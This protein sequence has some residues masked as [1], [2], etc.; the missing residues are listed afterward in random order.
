VAVFIN[1]ERELDFFNQI[2]NRRRPGPAQLVLLYG[3]RRIGKTALL[4]HWVDGQEILYTYWTA[5]KEPANLQRRKLFALLQNLPPHQGPLFDSWSELWEAT[6]NLI[7]EKRHI[8]V[9]D[10]LPYAV[11]ADPAML[12]ALQHAWDRHF[13]GSNLILVL[14]GSQVKTMES[15]QYQGSPLFGRL[16]GQWHLQPLS[17]STLRHFFPGWSAAERVAGYAMVGGVPAYLNWLDPELDLETNIRRIVLAE[18]GMFLAEPT[19]LLYD[20]VREPQSYLAVLKAIGLGNHTLGDIS[21]HTLIPTSHL[22]AHLTRL[23]DLKLVERRLPA[24]LHPSKRRRSKRGRYHLQD[25]FFRFYFRFI[26]P[27]YDNLPYDLDAVLKKVRSELRAFVGVSTFE[28][29]CRQWVFQQ[30][31]ADRLPLN[32]DIVGSHWS[33]RTQVDVTALNWE[34][35]RILLGECKWSHESVNRNIVRELLERKL[36][37]LL[38]DLPDQGEGWQT[39]PVIFSRSGFSPAALQDLKKHNGLA[40]DLSTLDADLD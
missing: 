5:E 15:I 23:Q 29:L 9:L 12:S 1:R 31:K 27:F 19:F 22:S 32:P 2:P 8:L 39:I 28:E 24:T 33:H 13:Q 37:R 26:A 4:R 40:V 18:G 38:D 34:E 35:R 11:D 25:P 10:E 17:F 3:R 14:C 36:P 20:E 6:A 21:R 7:V 30:G 16:T